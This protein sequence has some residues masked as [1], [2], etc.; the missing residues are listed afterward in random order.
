MP[1]CEQDAPDSL[2]LVVILAGG[3]GT[4]VRHLLPGVPK[5]MAAVAGRPFVEWVVR[6]FARHGAK[7][8]AIATG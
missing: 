5:P 3:F 4:R 8:F 2:P 7:E 6:F 1:T